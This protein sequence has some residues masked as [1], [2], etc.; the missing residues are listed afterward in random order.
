MCNEGYV[1]FDDIE[2]I[3][4]ENAKEIKLIPKNPKDSPKLNSH[5]DDH[6]FFFRYGDGSYQNCYSY[7]E[8]VHMNIG[9][10]LRQY[11]T[12]KMQNKGKCGKI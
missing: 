10:S 4:I 5:F 9:N 11:R 8:R 2:C 1:T 6:N 12:E 7:I 3:F